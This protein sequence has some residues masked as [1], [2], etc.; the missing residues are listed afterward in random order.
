MIQNFMIII[1]FQFI[2]IKIILIKVISKQ[3]GHILTNYRIHIESIQ[4]QIRIPI[5]PIQE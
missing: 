4:V 1:Q 3:K 5:I 2:K